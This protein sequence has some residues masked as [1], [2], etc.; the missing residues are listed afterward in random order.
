MAIDVKLTLQD[1]ATRVYN[2]F[3]GN[4]NSKAAT[5]DNTMKS[6]GTA[7]GTAFS[8]GAIVSFAKMAAEAEAGT[9]ALSLALKN[10]GQNSATATQAFLE[11]ADALKKKTAIDDDEIKRVQ[12]LTI[13]MTGNAQA[14]MT[15]TPAI[16]DLAIGMGISTEQAA[17]MFSKSLEGSE[18][19]KK[20]GIEIGKTANETERLGAIAE[21]VEKKW[22]GAAAA[23]ANTDAGKIKQISIAMDDLEKGVGKVFL[24]IL[25]PSLPGIVKMIDGMAWAFEKVVLSIK[26]V[27]ATIM[28]GLIAPFAAVENK[29]NELGISSSRTFQNFMISGMNQT[30]QAA[31][32]LTGGIDSAVTSTF[33]LASNASENASAI[34]GKLHPAI[35]GLNKDLSSLP[36]SVKGAST[37]FENLSTTAID[38][39][40]DIRDSFEALKA[41]TLQ[42][43]GDTAFSVGTVWD[44]TSGAIRTGMEAA[45]SGAQGAGMSALKAL[46]N[47]AINLAELYLST[48]LAEAFAKGVPTFGATLPV[49]FALVA[50]GTAALE[51]A[52]GAINRFH[53]GGTMAPDGS[54][55]PLQSDERHAI[56]KV[57]ET[58]LPTKPGES[59]GGTQIHNHFHFA[60]ANIA[61]PM[62]FKDVVEKGMRQLGV[63]DVSK[64]FVNQRNNLAI[65]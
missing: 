50:A 54:R 51:V 5:L 14:A 27:T 57:G 2:Q 44:A 26:V 55:I 21:A 58:V 10:A 7:I 39:M 41:G 56:L 4:V 3:V 48:A 6:L 52:R 45:F 9:A 11:Q 47:S 63:T 33:T 1:Q 16:L 31:I 32:E 65:A 43:A 59:F 36:R 25:G 34:R 15:L 30:K 40:Q 35:L 61:S 29:L 60:G 53:D 8:V 24:G 62:A 12:A 22:G 38:N 28:T 18:G 49:D 46:G 17:K 64:Y 20:A 42:T 37:A 23:F 19:L 13:G